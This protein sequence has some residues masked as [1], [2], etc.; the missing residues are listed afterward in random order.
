L[1]DLANENNLLNAKL[2]FRNLLENQEDYFLSAENVK[3]KSYTLDIIAENELG[4]YLLFCLNED[5]RIYSV[6]DRGYYSTKYSESIPFNKNNNI[7]LDL[8]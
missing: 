7:S 5:V 2:F 3:Y 1:V 6:D 4:E 8:I